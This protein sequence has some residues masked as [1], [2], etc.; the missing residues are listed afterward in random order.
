[1]Q[2]L[3]Y[4]APTSIGSAVT[5][6]A[7][8]DENARIFAG[9]TD[10]LVQ[11]RE[12]LIRPS[13]FIDIKKITETRTIS[14]DQNYIRIGA[15]ITGAELTGH[16]ELKSLIPGVTEA[17]GLIGSAQVQGRATIGG[18]L[19]NASPAADSVP[20]LIA[21]SAQAE[22][23]GPNGIRKISVEEI[24]SS[25]GETSLKRGEFI[26]SLQ[27]P[28]PAQRSASAY[29]R[30]IPRTEMDI[31]VVGAG[32]SVTLDRDGFCTSARLALGAVA[33]TA[34]Q[35][36]PVSRI[37]LGRKLDEATLQELS[38]AARNVCDPIDDK[39]GTIEFRTHVA[40]V[41]AKRVIK[42]AWHRAELR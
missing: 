30:F 21:V 38:E 32:S 6:L 20:S 13:V 8:A 2:D 37:L 33:P 3:N 40:G 14:I 31:A 15:A 29:L 5:A 4:E 18:N 42:V 22:V 25:P 7:A 10:L 26:V 36:E 9:G 41:L 23:A 1:M 17:A 11:L 39:R 28:T 19:C 35:V 24:L 27:I 34:R 16:R 12:D